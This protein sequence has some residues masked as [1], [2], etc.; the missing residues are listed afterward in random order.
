MFPVIGIMNII[1]AIYNIGIFTEPNN[2]KSRL[3]SYAPNR[4]IGTAQNATANTGGGGG[5]SGGGIGGSGFV[6]I[7]YKFQ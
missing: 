2:G 4:I 7:R 1:S 5:A 3:E 6:A